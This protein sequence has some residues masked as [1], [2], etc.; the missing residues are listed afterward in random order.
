MDIVNC[1]HPLETGMQVYP[2]D[3]A[4]EIGPALTVAEH[5]VNVLALHLGSQ[6]GTHLDSPFHV[7]DDLPTLDQL[8]LSL[9]LGRAVV[10]DATGLAPRSEIPHERFTAATYDGVRIVLVRTDWSQY[11]GTAH[12]LAHPAP[13]LASL[14]FL[15]ERGIRTIA[16]DCLSLDI[17]PVDPREAQLTNH[18]LWSEAGGVIGENFTNLAAVTPSTPYVS[19]LPL[20][21]GASDGAPIRAVAFSAFDS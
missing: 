2:G 5:G 8:D 4:V 6:S 1:S 18:Y 16:L 7:R 10:V 3:P 14:T 19:M 13:S 17:T 9:F 21:L 20:N 11:F 12:Y 15:L